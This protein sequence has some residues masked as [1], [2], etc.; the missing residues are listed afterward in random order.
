MRQFVTSENLDSREAVAQR[1][2]EISAVP[3]NSVVHFYLE[4]G[5]LFF[6]SHGAST[7]YEVAAGPTE[8]KELYWTWRSDPEPIVIDAEAV[9]TP[10]IRAIVPALLM[11]GISIVVLDVN[12]QH[13]EQVDWA[14]EAE[15]KINHGTYADYASLKP[16]SLMGRAAAE[17]EAAE[18]A[19]FIAARQQA[20]A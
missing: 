12:G 3:R 11:S 17:R 10:D 1:I 6:K 2:E 19:A 13:A 18:T 4:E 8:R 5:R 9:A 20:V 7:G 15:R 16:D 14:H